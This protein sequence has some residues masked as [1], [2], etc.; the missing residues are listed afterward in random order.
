MRSTGQKLQAAKIGSVM[1]G[2]EYARRTLHL[3][4]KLAAFPQLLAMGHAGSA[5]G[6]P[7]INSARPPPF[8]CCGPYGNRPP[9][10]TSVRVRQKSWP[11]LHNHAFRH[12]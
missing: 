4:P 6:G 11:P 5:A 2:D 9:S 3:V 12:R 1:L 8:C 7:R 10:H